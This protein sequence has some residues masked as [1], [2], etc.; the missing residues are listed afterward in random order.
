MQTII[1]VLKTSNSEISD[2]LLNRETDINFNIYILIFIFFP[3]KKKKKKHCKQPPNSLR[4][5]LLLDSFPPEFLLPFVGDKDVF[6]NYTLREVIK[7]KKRIL[8]FS[9]KTT[10][11]QDRNT[12]TTTTN[13]NY[14]YLSSECSLATDSHSFIFVNINFSRITFM[15][16]IFV[17]FVGIKCW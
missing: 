6:W 16:N 2:G 15:F 1:P 7:R 10:F 8:K 9:S 17:F 4:N 12:N 11:L 14:N 13:A 3:W 5:W